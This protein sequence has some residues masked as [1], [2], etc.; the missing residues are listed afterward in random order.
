MLTGAAAL[1][2]L[3]GIAAAVLL[4]SGAMS[5]AAT[6]QHFR[7]THRLLDLGLEFS[8][9]AKTESIRP[10]PLDSPRMRARGL[11][12]YREH[13]LACHGAPGEP[14]SPAALGMLPVPTNLAHAA[15]TQPPEW[16]YYVTRKGVRMT[17]MPAWE[18]R[19]ADDSLWDVVAFLASLPQL[20]VTRYR[21]AD[22]AAAA[23]DCPARTD[24]PPPEEGT[25]VLLRQYACHSCHRIEGVVGPQVDTAPPLVDWPRRALIAGVLPNSRDNLARWIEAPRE[26]SPQ[27]LMPDLGVPPEHARAMADFLFAQP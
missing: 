16:L 10:P 1:L 8:V 9:R 11:A 6:K 3:G 20:D 21:Q 24:L 22:A 25:D 19:L 4:L 12:C 7:V 18:Y 23:L 5:T 27:T 2:V 17:G 13:C 26:V 15:R 14:P